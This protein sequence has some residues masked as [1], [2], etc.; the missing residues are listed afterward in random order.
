MWSRV[1]DRRHWIRE[2]PRCGL[3]FNGSVTRPSYQAWARRLAGMGHS[4][5]CCCARQPL[6]R[7][8]I[9]DNPGKTYQP[10][11][12]IKEHETEILR[13]YEGLD[14]WDAPAIR[15]DSWE[16]VDG[17]LTLHA[18]RTT[19]KATLLTNRAWH[20][21]R[22]RTWCAGH[23]LSDHM[24]FQLTM[25]TADNRVPLIR[26]KASL[27][28]NPGLWQPAVTASVKAGYALDAA[29]TLTVQGLERAII[30]EC[31]DELKCQ[32]STLTPVNLLGVQRDPMEGGKP[33]LVILAHTDATMR[34]IEEGLA[35]ASGTALED[36]VDIMSVGVG[37]FQRMGLLPTRLT[38]GGM[39]LDTAPAYATALRWARQRLWQEAG[40]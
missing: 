12:A 6:T 29:G 2:C 33:S 14:V 19:Y 36:A 40:R 3:R 16:C 25:L 21:P 38:A 20:D 27:S 35:H 11:V 26:R 22:V 28:V 8:Y 23:P 9:E 39:R 10:P 24:G 18:S 15:L 34:D 32:P 5:E 30:R 17:T 37:A 4:E 31:A 1:G 13:L 7:V